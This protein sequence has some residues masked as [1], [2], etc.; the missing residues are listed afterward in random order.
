M[1]IIWFRHAAIVK[2]QLLSIFDI[3]E[4]VHS[5]VIF[6]IRDSRNRSTI[7]I[8]RMWK[9]TWKIAFFVGIHY[10]KIV[11]FRVIFMAFKINVIKLWNIVLELFLFHHLFNE[12]LAFIPPPRLIKLPIIF[13]NKAALL[14]S[15]F[16]YASC[17]F[18]FCMNSECCVVNFIYAELIVLE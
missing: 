6:S 8:A 12:I 14:N 3:S 13:N 18:S 1:L 2:S 16:F 9:T 4:T 10:H 15:L 5:N 17:P 7:W 11:T